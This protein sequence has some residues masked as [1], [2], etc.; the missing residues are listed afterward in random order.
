MN[1]LISINEQYAAPFLMPG[2]GIFGADRWQVTHSIHGRL[3]APTHPTHNGK[4]TIVDCAGI[5][6]QLQELH[7]QGQLPADC[8]AFR[9]RRIRA[10]N[11]TVL[12]W[13]NVFANDNMLRCA[14]F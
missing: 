7:L 12:R 3:T 13:P 4:C 5:L 2:N 1:T 14:I 10:K 8:A 9:M 11:L 6:P